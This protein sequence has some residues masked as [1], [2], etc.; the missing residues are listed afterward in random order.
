MQSSILTPAAVLVAWSLIVMV[1]MV[2]S[3]FGAFKTAK[4]DLKKAPPGG[5]GQDLEGRIP[6]VANWKSH[7]YTHLMEQPTLFYATVFILAM[8]GASGLDV[9][10]AWAY[11]LIRVVHS[12]WQATVNRV[13]VRMVL[14]MLSSVCLMILALRALLATLA[15]PLV[16]L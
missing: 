5:R 3:R 13:P 11:V 15:S 16:T 4:I 12:V 14:F 8:S 7:N 10:L 6:A 9:R 1:W 2:A